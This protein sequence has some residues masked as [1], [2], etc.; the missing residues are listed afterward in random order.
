M[1]IGFLLP[2]PDGAVVWRGPRKNGL[3]K[4]FLK[5]VDWGPLDWLI[6]DTPP[7]TSDEHISLAQLL[8]ARPGADGALLV[9]TPQEVAVADVRKEAAFCAKVGLPL[10][11]VVENMAALAAPAADA[12]LVSSS[13]GADVTAAVAA[14]VDGA[15]GAGAWAGLTVRVPIFHVPGGV[16]GG[17]ALAARAGTTL[18][19]RVPLDPGLGRACEEGAW[20]GPDRAPAAAAALAGVCDGVMKALGGAV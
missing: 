8:P 13:T 16:G 2:D 10:V 15:L 19:G 12:A 9:T 20:A 14:A 5:D 3:I 6:I 18:L 11:G 7:G 4:Q 1:S 17:A